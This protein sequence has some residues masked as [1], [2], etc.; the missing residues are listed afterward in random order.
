MFK[1]L[2]QRWRNRRPAETL[3]EVVIAVFVVALGS[4]AATSLIVSAMQANSFSKDNLIALYLATEAVEGVRNIRDT[5]WIRYGFDKTNCWN[6]DP[7]PAVAAT[8]TAPYAQIPEGTYSADLD[9]DTSA[10]F[11][12]A[13]A[14]PLDLT[15]AAY[16]ATNDEYLLSFYDEDGVGSTHD[17]YIPKTYL[18]IIGEPSSG[19]SKFYRMIEITYE[20]TGDPSSDDI[21]N[22]V[23]T[24][25]WW[26]NTVHQVQLSTSLSNYQKVPTT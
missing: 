15:N 20:P 23:V 25:N 22:V 19:D 14:N 17:L 2:T 26:Q 7:D 13:V 9:P 5:N 10:W 16:S 3:V 11:L 6:L 8:C 21:M 18:G 12:R 4:G 24:V 1:K